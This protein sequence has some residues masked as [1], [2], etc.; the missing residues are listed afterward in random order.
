MSRSYGIIWNSHAAW[1]LWLFQTWIFSGSLVCSMF[2]MY[3]PEW[4]QRIYGSKGREAE[5]IG[6]VKGVESCKTVFLGALPIHL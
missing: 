6:L 2:L 5:E 4:H 3:A 1:C